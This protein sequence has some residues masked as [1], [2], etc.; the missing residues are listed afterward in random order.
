MDTVESCFSGSKSTFSK[1]LFSVL[2]Y[3][4]NSS[5]YLLGR[6]LFKQQGGVCYKDVVLS[7]NTQLSSEDPHSVLGFLLSLQM[8]LDHLPG[9]F[10]PSLTCVP[11]SKI[12]LCISVLIFHRVALGS[13]C[14]NQ[15]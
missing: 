3:V 1:L 11:S 8:R 14:E 9:T 13:C 7:R 4:Q 2:F 10:L 15:L 5:L 12:L 6:C